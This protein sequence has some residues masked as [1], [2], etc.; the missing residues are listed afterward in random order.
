MTKEQYSGEFRPRISAFDG[1]RDQLNPLLNSN[2][3]KQRLA[4]IAHYKSANGG[5]MY[6]HWV[7]YALRNMWTHLYR[8]KVNY[9]VKGFAGYMVYRDIQNFQHMNSVQFMTYQQQA[10]LARPA[11]L[12]LGVFLGL[13]AFI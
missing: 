12:N 9:A 5:H 10:A 3:L 1:S 7:H 11:A 4:L 6:Q 2:V 8:Y 13:C